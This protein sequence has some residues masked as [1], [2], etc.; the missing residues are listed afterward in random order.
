MR[1]M[2]SREEN[3][4]SLDSHVSFNS[5][6]GPSLGACSQAMFHSVDTVKTVKQL[7]PPFIQSLPSDQTETSTLIASRF[8]V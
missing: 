2:I 7:L 4:V 8:I 1:D 3:S 5:P 6:S